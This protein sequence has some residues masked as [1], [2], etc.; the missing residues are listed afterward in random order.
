MCDHHFHVISD[1]LRA[2]K[3]GVTVNQP[4][5]LKADSNFLRPKGTEDGHGQWHGIPKR[6]GEYNPDDD[7]FRDY[8]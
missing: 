8:R 2:V 7:D 6:H 1:R 3:A 4:V 5:T